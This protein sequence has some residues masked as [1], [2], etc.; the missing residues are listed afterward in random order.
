MEKIVT[1]SEGQA[2][3]KKGA[4]TADH[5]FLLRG[6]M[7]IAIA[8]KKNLFIT[9]YD[10]V[11]AYDQA[12]V[13]NML[14]VIWESGVRGKIWRI[15]K[16]F[17]TNQQAFV[18]TRYGP[19]RTFNRENGG[20]QGSR[21]TCR[22]F[23]KQMDVLSEISINEHQEKVVLSEKLSIGCLEFVDDALTCTTGIN[24]QKS[25]LKVAENKC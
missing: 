2:G 11:K 10:V 9:F 22:L 15:V 17:S 24:N 5:L 21:L 4:S 1:L 20:R 18:K 3:G 8:E 19:T 6:L 16:E 12:D 25:I 13:N 7:S 14:H 23:S